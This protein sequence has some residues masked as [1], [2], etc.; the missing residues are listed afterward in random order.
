MPTTKNPK[1]NKSRGVL[2]KRSSLSTKAILANQLKKAKETK[3]NSKYCLLN[4]NASKLKGKKKSGTKKTKRYMLILTMRLNMFIPRSKNSTVVLP[5]S[6]N[7][8]NYHLRSKSN[9]HYLV[10]SVKLSVV[11]C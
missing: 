5:G 10:N 1:I 4:S 3:K 9:F 8:T 2:L 7:L 11:S 6:R